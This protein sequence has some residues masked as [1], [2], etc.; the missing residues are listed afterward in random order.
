MKHLFKIIEL[1]AAVI[2]SAILFP[3]GLVFNICQ[4]VVLRLGFFRFVWLF[5]LETY[6]IVLD[7]F[8]KIAV[9]IDRYGNVILSGLF[10]KIFI[11]NTHNKKTLFGKSEVTISASLGHALTNFYLNGKG[12]KFCKFIDK[13]FGKN[14]CI[15]AYEF[16]IIKDKFNSKTG[17]S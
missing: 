11:K 5:I 10:I 2:L 3:I 8:E 13:V 16:K 14:H 4:L 12:L 15:L 17:I 1:L 7:L 9:I 6:K